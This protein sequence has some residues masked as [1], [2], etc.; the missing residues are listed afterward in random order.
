M[1]EPVSV[2]VPAYN[3]S[4]GIEAA[5]R[6]LVASTT[7]LEIIV[8]DDGST[9]GTADL[10]EAL[11]LPGVRVIRQAERRQAGRPQ[12]R[13]R[14]C[15][16]TTSSCMVDGDTV[17]EPDTVHAL[18]QPFAD[19]RR[20]RGLRQHQGR[21][22]RRPA[23]PLAAHRVRHRLQP[24]P[25][26]VRRA[27]VHADRARARSAPS[28]A[29]R[30]RE[31]GGVSDDTLAEDTDLTMASC[32]D[33]WRVVY[34]GDAQGLD[35]GARHARRA[36]AAAVPLVL[37]H[38]AG[39]V[40]APRRVVA[41]RRGRQARPARTALP[42]RSSRCCCR[43][44]RRSS[45]SF[46]LYGLIFLDPVRIAALWLA[47][48]VVQLVIAAYAFRL[49]GEPLGPLWTLPLQQFVYRQ[50]MYLVVIQ[51][52]VTALPGHGCGGT[53][54]SGTAACRPPRAP[55][56]FPR[57]PEKA[58]RSLSAARKF[59]RSIPGNRPP[60]QRLQP[61]HPWAEQPH[62]HDVDRLPGIT[63]ETWSPRHAWPG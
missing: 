16:A 51:S 56:V 14:R 37:R 3:E 30:S 57:P 47:F 7:R 31:V 4:A 45:T 17:F 35:R 48:L 52:V 13:H 42:A 9:D 25:P 36:V 10:V 27:R 40:E 49:D 22:P 53:E 15:H 32:R 23:R 29:R 19:P 55:K 26:D 50:L 60:A 21:Q 1:T 38:D 58:R 11:D 39:D 5:V 33:G 2:I 8:V 43:C 41:A 18:V 12:H 54:W 46:A 59:L 6:S 61:V 62:Q 28:A 63:P 34:A 44:S 24:R 20:R